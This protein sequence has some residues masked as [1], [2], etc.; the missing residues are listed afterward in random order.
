MSPA[1]LLY[2]EAKAVVPEDFDRTVT[3]RYLNLWENED[4]A[5]SYLA[6]IPPFSTSVYALEM[7]VRTRPL[8]C[9]AFHRLV[10]ALLPEHKDDWDM[11]CKMAL[12]AA[13]LKRTDPARFYCTVLNMSKYSAYF[14]YEKCLS[15]QSVQYWAARSRMRPDYKWKPF[16]MFYKAMEYLHSS[17]V[18]FALPEKTKESF[19]LAGGNIITVPSALAEDS[20]KR[21]S[22]AHQE[23]IALRARLQDDEDAFADFISNRNAVNAARDKA[24]ILYDTGVID[25]PTWGKCS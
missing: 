12:F 5:A 25:A 14:E 10:E 13:E 2:L 9:D 6:L 15:L 18:A 24:R 8:T 21:V 17:S 11:V 3:L 4:E 16:Y 23:L 19:E 7:F 20:K 22:T 1:Y